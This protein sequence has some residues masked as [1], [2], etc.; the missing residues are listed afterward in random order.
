MVHSNYEDGPLLVNA[1]CCNESMFAF[2]DDDEIAKNC[3]E[4]Y[5]IDL[6]YND[7][8]QLNFESYLCFM[9]CIFT[10][11][12]LLINNSINMENVKVDLLNLTENNT[13][14]VNI[15]IESMEICSRLSNNIMDT[16]RRNP[17]ARYLFQAK[18]SPMAQIVTDCAAMEYF[19]NCPDK[20]WTP[21]AECETMKFY[22]L[23]NRFTRF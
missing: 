6:K 13:D 2:Q 22:A 15:M 7:S 21:T 1:E 4:K 17:N 19:I 20:Y 18:C 14:L 9:D 5:G 23:Q 12:Q 16:L 11:N 3:S 8:E 10:E